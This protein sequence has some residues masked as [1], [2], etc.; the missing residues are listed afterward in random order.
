MGRLPVA[1]VALALACLTGC[2]SND[3]DTVTQAPLPAKQPVP[4]VT[5]GTADSD[6]DATV[7]DTE[8]DPIP[9]KPASKTKQ[10]AT[11]DPVS[12]AGSTNGGGGHP[13]LSAAAKA[14][15]QRLSATLGGRNGIAVSALGFD[16]PVYH[17]GDLTTGVAWS[18]SKVPVSMAIYDAG[19]ARQQA[20]NLRS[21][22]TVSDNAAAMRLWDA[23]GSGEKAAQLADDELRS[24]GDDTTQ[25][26]SQT[27][28]SGLTPFGQT[29]WSLTDQARFTAGMPCTQAGAQ[30][31]GLMNQVDP[32]QRWGLGSAGVPFQLKGGWGPGINPGQ[33]GGYFDRQMGVLTLMGNKPVAVTIATLPAD[34][35]HE[36]GTRNLTQ[37]AQWAAKN[38]DPAQAT[39]SADC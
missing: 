31:L 14:G 8:V 30:V 26:Q 13:L 27:L 32:S 39:S 38:I 19:L 5:A 10:P 15:F 16:K 2:G 18:T 21:A 9:T 29:M 3:S 1:A 20:S 33:S 6:G 28:I 34:G 17:A 24:A 23:L 12:D 37:I 7:T 11:P 36:T 22:I 4:A 35:S 25:V